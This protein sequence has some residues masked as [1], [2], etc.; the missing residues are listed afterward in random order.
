MHWDPSPVIKCT[1]VSTLILFFFLN[2]TKSIFHFDHCWHSQCEIYW[3]QTWM[4]ASQHRRCRFNVGRLYNLMWQSVHTEICR[5]PRGTRSHICCTS[6]DGT[7]CACK[8]LQ[9]QCGVQE[10]QEDACLSPES[11]LELMLSKKSNTIQWLFQVS[12]R[13]IKNTWM[14]LHAM[15]LA[16]FNLNTSAF[17]LKHVWT[18][19]MV[20]RQH[21]NISII[22][23]FKAQRT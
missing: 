17:S 8:L 19:R 6:M 3:T 1:D 9:W 15:S 13:W 10:V 16:L 2:R 11:D 12:R 5:D 7:F 18:V 4:A 20:R 21:E 14:P 22:F 23:Q